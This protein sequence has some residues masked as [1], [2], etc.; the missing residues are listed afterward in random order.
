[1]ATLFYVKF[2]DVIA[3]MIAHTVTDLNIRRQD[4]A[5]GRSQGKL[6]GISWC[7]K[8]EGRSAPTKAAANAPSP[9]AASWHP[10]NTQMTG[11][12]LFADGG[13]ECRMLEMEER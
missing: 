8:P 10:D 1:M 12:I 13:F 9:E 4:C 3:N 7:C 11:Q 2:R 6:T 5:P